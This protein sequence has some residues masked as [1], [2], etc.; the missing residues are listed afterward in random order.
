MRIWKKF[1]GSYFIDSERC[2]AVSNTQWKPGDSC[3]KH[4][5]LCQFRY[6]LLW[7][8]KPKIAAILIN[9][10]G[11]GWIFDF[12]LPEC[13]TSCTW[14][15]LSQSCT[16]FLS[17]VMGAKIYSKLSSH[18]GCGEKLSSY[19][20]LQNS[21]LCWCLNLEIFQMFMFLSQTLT[22]LQSQLYWKECKET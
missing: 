21:H 7:V 10:S 17:K 6:F 18:G 5:L 9:V 22:K 14:A 12:W 8:I 19:R 11:E 4:C 20:V 15:S 1:K 16:P 2:Q 13:Q 3:I